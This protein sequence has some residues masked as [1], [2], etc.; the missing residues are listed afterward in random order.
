[1]DAMIGLMGLRND[2]DPIPKPAQ[3]F[4]Y[5]SV[6]SWLREG[7]VCYVSRML[8]ARA[9]PGKP[10]FLHEKNSVKFADD[11]LK[12][13]CCMAWKWRVPRLQRWL[14]TVT[15]YS[16]L[17][18]SN[19]RQSRKS[20]AVSE[21]QKAFEHDAFVMLIRAYCSISDP[22]CKRACISSRYCPARFAQ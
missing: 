3:V 15:Q 6:L 7:M 17:E 12:P 14:L 20:T 19:M 8:V 10:D 18:I 22:V 13:A 9:N 4:D 5:H 2:L 11:V 1:M 16:R 21:H